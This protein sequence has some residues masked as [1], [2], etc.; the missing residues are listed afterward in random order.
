L[1]RLRR[2]LEPR[3]LVTPAADEALRRDLTAEIAAAIDDVERLPPPDSGTLFADVYAEAPWHL[4]EQLGSLK[5]IVAPS[6]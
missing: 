6:T 5:N 3:G 2:T 4:R 1:E